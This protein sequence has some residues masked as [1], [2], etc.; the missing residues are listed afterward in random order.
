MK[1][2]LRKLQNVLNCRKIREKV[3]CS[4]LIHKRMVSAYE[5]KYSLSPRRT[6][7]PIIDGK[8]EDEEDEQDA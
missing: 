2:L 4:T 8:R 7:V 1:H 6:R 5:R 3:L